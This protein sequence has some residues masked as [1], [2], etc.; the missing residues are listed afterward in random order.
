MGGGWRNR[1]LGLET[2]VEPNQ[3]A[4]GQCDLQRPTREVEMLR[5]PCTPRP[6]DS[7][8]GKQASPWH[9]TVRDRARLAEGRDRPGM[10]ETNLLGQQKKQGQEQGSGLRLRYSRLAGSLGAAQ[11]LWALLP[12]LKNGGGVGT[13]LP[14]R[15][16]CDGKGTMSLRHLVQ[17]SL[18]N[19]GGRRWVYSWGIGQPSPVLSK[20]S[21]V[22]AARGSQNPV[23]PW[24]RPTLVGEGAAGS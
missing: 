13:D 14:A 20:E 15:A 23:L 1:R 24:P 22:C 2:G 21:A 16:V 7:R 10:K 9:P 8:V 18:G 11:A 3:P 5:A 12:P 19:A 4:A 17:P 6:G